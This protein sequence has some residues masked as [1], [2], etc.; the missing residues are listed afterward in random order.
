VTT[1]NTTAPKPGKEVEK[2]K[3]K[4]EHRTPYQ[5]LM[6]LRESTIA[7]WVFPIF[8]GVVGLL[9][10]IAL[11]ATDGLQG[12][13]APASFPATAAAFI[14]WYNLIIMIWPLINAA[15]VA[16]M[17]KDLPKREPALR[18]LIA[19]LAIVVSFAVLVHLMSWVAGWKVETL[20][21]F[22]WCLCIASVICNGVGAVL[23]AR[24]RDLDP[25]VQKTQDRLNIVEGLIPDAVKE[26]T[27]AAF[28][29]Q[30]AQ[31][32]FDAREKDYNLLHQDAEDRVKDLAKAQ[33]AVDGLAIS[34]EKAQNVKRL[35]DL[36][37]LDAGR[38][39]NIDAIEARANAKGVTPAYK[40]KLMGELKDAIDKREAEVKEE[41]ELETRN[42]Q[43]DAE[44]L[45]TQQ[46][47]DLKLADT[48]SVQ[49]AKDEEAAKTRMEDAQ[50]ALTTATDAAS[51]KATT[52]KAL[53]DEKIKLT[54]RLGKA[55]KSSR[56]RDITAS[57]AGYLILALVLYIVSWY[58]Y[59]MAS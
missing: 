46:H 14:G 6:D 3:E 39:D 35:F 4:P 21:P 45:L 48:K 23:L 25:K 20:M 15:R 31:G 32:T 26:S 2:Y 47:A 13:W 27:S 41:A 33:E 24:Y 34:D 49:A 5:F 17:R 9:L 40:A 52:A 58:P 29:K 44:I 30:G 28:K 18:A 19:V 59:A 1:T 42:E 8:V 7:A 16:A 43:I 56:W 55:R 11:F 57:P 51:T 12:I 10:V 36:K 38:D 54:E 50:K 22:I 53:E 37:A